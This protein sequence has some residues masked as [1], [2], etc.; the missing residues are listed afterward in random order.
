MDATP[1]LL[2][3]SKDILMP[4]KILVLSDLTI[5]QI[6]AG[7][8]IENPASVVKEL[9]EN[10]IDAGSRHLKIEIMGGGFQ[11]LKVSDDGF[12]M[13]PD[14]AV[15]CLERH[16]TSKII[17]ADDLH[18]LTTMGFRGEALASIA[19]ISKMRL[20]SAI[21]S[22]TAVELEV[23]GGKVVHVG[24]SARSRG[25][26]IEV[27]SLFFNV[28]AR[29]KFQKSPASSSAEITKVVT[30]LALAH[31]EV[32]FD[33]IQQNR[34]HFSL[35]P[36]SGEDLI[37]LLKRR[38]ESL[39]G[40]EFLPSCRDFLF[41]EM[42][43][44][45]IGLVASPEFS[46]YNRSGQYLFINH[47]PVYCPAIA[48]AVRDAYGTRLNSDRHPVYLLHLSIPSH[49]VD[50][51]VHPQKKE[52]RLREESILKYALSNA[53]NAALGNNDPLAKEDVT[54]GSFFTEP[55]V[56]DFSHAFVFREDHEGSSVPALPMD[57][58]ISLIGLHGAYV[59]VNA[60]TMPSPLFSEEQRNSE[61][62][63]WIDL[64]AA[65]ARI[66]FDALVRQ[67]EKNPVSQGLLLPISLS[68][69]KAETELLIAHHDMIQKLGL[70]I[71]QAG[72]FSFLIE[73][74][75]PFLKEGEVQALLIEMIGELQ[76]I[77]RE[78][79][80]SE[81]AL[82]RLAARVS[83]KS[84]FNRQF[85]SHEEARLIVQKL[86]K[87]SSPLH[88]PQGKRTLVHIREDEIEKYF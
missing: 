50:V 5:N 24:P 48:Y 37:T 81:E 76:G 51:N 23:E 31:P 85:Y 38:S 25:T 82:R 32:G 6:A 86:M 68:F 44:E 88:C 65:E 3:T 49:L 18:S 62:V 60:D 1:I 17:D 46:R 73:G 30:Q 21:E 47:R 57:Y 70:M 22:A 34:S 71:R 33:L 16:A 36:S 64:P 52:I 19:S 26:T 45:G 74:I 12:G 53:V 83:R 29:K 72:E 41:K 80:Q 56:S 13:S 77:E 63:V 10:A 54:F 43:Y 55:V 8:V 84:R 78:K 7:E 61:G 20:L 67:A 42:D 79:T 14:D 35:P 2:T 28:P 27:R 11:L 15:L 58:P 4:N 87:T 39:L 59:L 40:S 75:P 9:V 66:Q 69:S